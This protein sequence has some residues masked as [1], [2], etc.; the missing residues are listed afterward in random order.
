MSNQGNLQTEPYSLLPHQAALI[1]QFFADPSKQGYLLQS[2][3]GLDSLHTT[4]HIIKRLMEMQP[5]ARILLLVPKMLQAATSHVLAR[6]GVLAEV[7]DRFRYRELQDA[8]LS[9]GAIWR[10]GGVFILSMDFGKQDD[11]ASSLA[12]VQWTMLIVP[13]AHTLRGLRKQVVQRIAD[14]SP[15][16]RIILVTTIGADDVPTFGIGP[17]VTI[18]WR[19]SQIVDNS[20]QRLFI[21]ISP[22]LEI[23]K[24]QKSAIEQRIQEAVTEIAE[25]LRAN[26]N[27][28]S[29]LGA[30]FTRSLSS[31]PAALEEGLRRLRTR[32][33]E[34]I[35]ESV[36]PVGEEDE[37]TDTENLPFINPAN[38]EDLIAALDKCLAELEALSIDSKLNGFIKAFQALQSNQPS[39]SL[40]CI[41]TESRATLFY[42]QTQLEEMGLTQH[43]LHGSMSF[44]DRRRNVDEFKRHGDVLLSTSAVAEGLN[45]S[46]VELLVLYDSPRSMLGLRKLYGRFNRLGRTKPLLIQILVEDLTG[47]SG[48]NDILSNL[49]E[50]LAEDNNDAQA[51]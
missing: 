22:R 2:D 4:A 44:D 39:L 30:F 51:R 41:F 25:L 28:G 26:N 10:T 8:A 45:L 18:H 17:F 29:L 15:D 1:E 21:Q 6:V 47:N 11:I 35:S 20:G 27:V 48:K 14:S 9:G 24:Y 49:L 37:E 38:R 13:E 16:L 31:S 40:V 33:T 34:G 7:V 46:Q 3:V 42:L 43:V 36:L 32:L 12:G 23:I 5:D 50:L 19:R